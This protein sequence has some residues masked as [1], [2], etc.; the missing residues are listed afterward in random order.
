MD[1]LYT[2]ESHVIATDQDTVQSSFYESHTLQHS[3]TL[4]PTTLLNTMI[5][6]S[7]FTYSPFT[8]VPTVIQ[9]D[10]WQQSLIS[11]FRTPTDWGLLG[12]LYLIIKHSHPYMAL[13]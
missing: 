10:S 2:T 7:I 8:L 13:A 4:M 5:Y 9:Y 1:K 3:P 12:E 11:I 6:I